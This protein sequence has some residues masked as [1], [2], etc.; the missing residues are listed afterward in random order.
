MFKEKKYIKSITVSCLNDVAS[1]IFPPEE[2]IVY[3]NKDKKASK[4]IETKNSPSDKENQAIIIPINAEVASLK[5]EIKNL[6]S[7]PEWHEGKGQK[8]WLF[9]DE[10]IFN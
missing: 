6:K 4:L 3:I 7:I 2:I 9:M 10:W 8:A 1:W 5:V